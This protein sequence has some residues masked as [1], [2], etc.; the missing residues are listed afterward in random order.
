MLTTWRAAASEKLRPCR[1]PPVGA[2]PW[3]PETLLIVSAIDK[4]NH[5]VPLL[6][7]MLACDQ[8]R[9]GGRGGG[10]KHPDTCVRGTAR[11]LRFTEIDANQTPIL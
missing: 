3:N 7:V 1:A 8:Q 6:S 10:S 2:V 5:G 9:F 4:A 11:V